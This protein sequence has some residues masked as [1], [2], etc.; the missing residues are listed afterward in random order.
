M[1]AT[2]RTAH[3]AGALY[4]LLG[5]TGFYNLMIVPGKVVVAGDAA[6]TARNI[7][8]SEL[9]YRVGLLSGLVSVIAFTAMALILYDFFKGVNK[10][11]ARLLLTLV[12]IQVVLG[13]VELSFQAAP[14]VLLSGADYLSALTKPQLDALSMAFLRLYSLGI[15][16]NTAFWGLWLF[17]FGILAFKSGWFPKVLG[18]LLVIAGAGYLVVSVTSILFPAHARAVDQVMMPVYSIGEGAMILWL[19]VMGAKVPAQETQAAA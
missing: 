14:L 11:Y 1:Q 19:L 2:K 3:I 18:V 15:D 9:T 6:A 4:V 17:P 13:V 7:V 10:A 5:I 8:A 16:F 12:L